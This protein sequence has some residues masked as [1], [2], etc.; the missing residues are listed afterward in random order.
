M[1]SF[2]Y[3]LCISA[4]LFLVA[5]ASAAPVPNS[6]LSHRGHAHSWIDTSAVTSANV[7]ALQG[8]RS[9]GFINANQVYAFADGAIFRLFTAPDKVSDITLQPGEALI[10]ISAGDTARW[11]IG[12]TYS[13]DGVSKQTHVLV[14]P[15]TVG[16]TTNLVI[17][18][19]R[20]TYHIQLES[21]AI[22]AMTAISWSYPQD[23]LIA[24]KAEAEKRAA[25]APVASGLSIENLNF[26]YMVT[27]DTPSWRPVRVF[28]DGQKTYIQ[29]P[30]TLAQGEAPPL[31][32]LGQDGKAE[33]VNYRLQHDYYVA[34]RLFDAA[35]LRLGTKHQSVV[36]ISRITTQAS[37]RMALPGIGGGHD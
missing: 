2:R 5:G 1:R 33:L 8:P 24:F 22:A 17:T 19:D 30:P 32:V 35:E 28:D 27:G 34:D 12:D 36:R 10:A 9:D 25:E 18:T 26:G 6:K 20:R 4:S 23:A 7:A 11:I 31:F 16:L 37:K 14:K 3:A 21:T 15:F 13:G 29:F